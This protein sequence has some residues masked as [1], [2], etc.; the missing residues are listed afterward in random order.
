MYIFT[1]NLLMLNCNKMV[2]FP[3]LRHLNLDL[4]PQFVIGL[5]KN[6]FQGVQW[7]AP[8]SSLGQYARATL[9]KIPLCCSII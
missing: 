9:Y 3:F 4:F 5:K 7:K 8:T 1:S 2:T 6:S